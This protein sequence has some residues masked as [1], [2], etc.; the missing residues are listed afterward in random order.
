[1]YLKALVCCVAFV[2]GVSSALAQS[3]NPGKAVGTTPLSLSGTFSVGVQSK[4]LKP[5]FSRVI[6]DE[7]ALVQ[8]LTLNLSNGLF[9]DVWN[10]IGLNDDAASAGRGNEID[11]TVGYKGKIEGLDF[12]LSFGVVDLSSLGEIRQ[13]DLFAFS[14]SLSKTFTLG[15]WEGT[16]LLRPEFRFDW[17][18]E[19]EQWSNN[20]PVLLPS[21]RHTWQ[22]PFGFKDI[23]V[24]EQFGLQWSGDFGRNTSDEIFF[25]MS[26]GLEWQ[27]DDHI[28]F[29]PNLMFVAPLTG[30]ND[31]RKAEVACGINMV[32][33]F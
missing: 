20:A 27:V 31:G 18:F 5:R 4:L 8:N 21:V 9:F 6:Y 25:Q 2:F 23:T 11:L 22:K 28:K 33:S 3:S 32:F 30:G 19:A 15:E 12:K 26:L 14:A 16:H 10:S 7:P 1:M 13:N 17:V 24:F 29:V